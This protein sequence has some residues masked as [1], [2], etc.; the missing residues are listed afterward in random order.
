MLIIDDDASM[1]LLLA[2]MARG[3]GVDVDTAPN[4]E[5][6]LEM[7]N[8][9]VYDLVLSDIRM[10]G[11]SGIEVLAK[12][13]ERQPGLPVI[14]LTAHGS[15]KAAVQAMRDGAFDYILKPVDEGELQ[16]II[17]RALEYS[18]L[19]NE[20]AY[21][22]AEM[23]D[24]SL[25]AGRLLGA[26]EAMQSVFDLIH[27]VARSDSTVLITGETGTGKELVAQ[28]IH[29]KSPRADHPFI[30][31]NCAALHENLLESELFGHERGAFT[32]A[33]TTRRG[34]FEM[35]DGGTIFLDEIGETS[36]EFQANLLRVLQEGEFERVG[37][38]RKIKVNVRVIASTNRDIKEEV[39]SGRFRED[40]YYRLRVVPIVLP[41]LRER[42]DDILPLAYYFLDKF[43]T[44]YEQ[45][46]TGISD[47][48]REWL[49]RQEWKGNV[50][51]LEH[52]IERAA[53]L[54]PGPELEAND[55]RIPEESKSGEADAATR[56]QDVIDRTTREHIIKILDSTSWKK[57]RAA[58]L[59]GID[60]ATLYRLLKKLGI[61][62]NTTAD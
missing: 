54:A 35:A 58:E 40:L 30:A 55:L 26:S 31:C 44:R 59:L 57:Q 52:T 37:G 17:E 16:I 6:A 12:I 22:R 7:L 60:R 25:F 36:R 18:R 42:K 4:G 47:D 8:D 24:D 27:R 28:T 9:K 53:V 32:G 33:V 19:R 43:G 10:P 39:A 29:F 49:L 45:T 48:G 34:R 5:D 21:L 20:N 11:M 46:L 56:L 15:V 2:T 1:T 14:L 61:S 13:R 38:A 23:T 41:P 62:D 50:R 3:C 51:E